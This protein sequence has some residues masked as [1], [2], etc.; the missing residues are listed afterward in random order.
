MAILWSREIAKERSLSGKY[1][2]TYSYTRAFLV[3]TDDPNES[4]ADISNNP[5][6]GYMDAHPQDSSVNM[7][8]FDVKPAD[9]SGL[10]YVVSFKYGPP[11]PNSSESPPAEGPEPDFIPALM[12][13]AVWTGSSS[14]T[15]G[16]ITE[17]IH[18]VAITN[19]ADDPLEDVVAERAEF[20]LQVTLY[21]LSHTVWMPLALQFTNA[22][23]DA[24]WNGGDAGTWKC[25][26]CSARL[27]SENNGTAATTFWEL[28]WDFAYREGGWDLQLLDIG[29]NQL[30]DGG[31][32]GGTSANVRK[33]S[34]KG[35]DGKGSKQPLGL[36]GM[37]KFVG[38][39]QKPAVTTYET[40]RRENFNSTFG[41]V[42]TP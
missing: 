30:S 27:T 36:N 37:G 41:Q 10:L 14:I 40:Y 24:T 22:T 15:T 35:V 5:G 20:K 42:Y 1:Q 13:Q 2:D 29:F 4:L 28:T 11:P 17:D 9:D 12:K 16:P 39:G 21:A 26:G 32:D 25:Q 7:L 34:A 6:P 33:E 3:R 23:N 19:S 31:G 18:G 38:L 8:E